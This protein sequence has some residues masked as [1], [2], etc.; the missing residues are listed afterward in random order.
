MQEIRIYRIVWK[1]LLAA[2]I[3]LAFT[4]ISIVLLLQGKGPTAKVTFG[5]LVFGSSGVFLLYLTLKVRLRPYLI[6]TDK[7][8]IQSRADRFLNDHEIPFSEV[9]HFELTPFNIL[10]P[11]ERDLKVYYKKDKDKEKVF[12]PTILG[13]IASKLFSGADE[14]IAVSG[15]DM[16]PQLLCDLLNDR[17][18]CI[19][20]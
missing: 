3:C 17:V 8:L 15:I 19:M 9:D 1:F 6:V 13:R 20:C 12:N 2:I 7:S 10:L 4:V 5:L 11:F 14:F 18:R 16:K